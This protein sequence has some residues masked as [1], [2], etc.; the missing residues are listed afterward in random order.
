MSTLEKLYQVTFQKVLVKECG[1][2]SRM[3]IA[4]KW[5]MIRYCWAAGRTYHYGNWNTTECKNFR[6]GLWT[7]KVCDLDLRGTASRMAPNKFCLGYYRH[8][9]GIPFSQDILLMFDQFTKQTRDRLN[10]RPVQVM[11]LLNLLSRQVSKDL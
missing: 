9:I 1:D 3:Q 5:T 11:D 6:A 2:K 7:F 8:T 10:L 4:P